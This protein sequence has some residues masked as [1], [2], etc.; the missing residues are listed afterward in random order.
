MTD[1]SPTVQSKAKLPVRDAQAKQAFVA[2]TFIFFLGV[3][4]G[5]ALAKAF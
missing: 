2:I 4:V 3:A 1:E 5:F